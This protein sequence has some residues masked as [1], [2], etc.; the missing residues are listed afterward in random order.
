M[1]E[2][3]PAD[4][5]Q[6]FRIEGARIHTIEDLYAQ[7]NALLM[8]GE[9][10][11]LG[12][13]LDALNDVLYR[14]H[15]SGALGPTV[16]VWADHEYSRKALGREATQRWLEEKLRHPDSF[17][18]RAIRAQRDALL[19]GDG[20]TYFDIVQEIFVAHSPDVHLILA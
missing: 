10:W 8:A 20:K 7:L 18:V 9:G 1:A 15:P 6:V 19:A 14:F 16:F 17:D 5:A 12:V 11:E 3:S 4:S 13:S 2:E